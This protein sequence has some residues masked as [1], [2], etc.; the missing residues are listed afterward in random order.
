MLDQVA[1][2]P[3]V[4][5]IMPTFDDFITGM[6]AFGRSIQPLMQC[7]RDRVVLEHRAAS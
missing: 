2:I 4:K 5:G 6:D 7:H 1:T 3:G